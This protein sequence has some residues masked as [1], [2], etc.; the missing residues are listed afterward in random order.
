MDESLVAKFVITAIREFAVVEGTKLLQKNSEVD[1]DAKLSDYGIT[2]FDK[3]LIVAK[4]EQQF[5]EINVDENNISLVKTGNAL[6]GLMFGIIPEEE[7]TGSD[8]TVDE[9]VKADTLSS[10]ACNCSDTTCECDE[11]CES[12]SETEVTISEP[13]EEVSKKKSTKKKVVKGK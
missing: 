4:T 11:T 3:I 6:I 7:E 10:G 12:K 8:E 13:A 1:L 9:E 5:P 2:T